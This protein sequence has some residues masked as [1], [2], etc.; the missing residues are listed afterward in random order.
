MVLQR[1][2]IVVQMQALERERIGPNS[3]LISY[4]RDKL[5]CLSKL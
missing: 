5:H 2:G 3:Y 4:Y 1:S